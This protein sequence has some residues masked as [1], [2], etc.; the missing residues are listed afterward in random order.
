MENWQRIGREL[1][2]EWCRTGGGLVEN[3]WRNGRELMEDLWRIGR[4][5]TGGRLVEDD[6]YSWWFFMG[7]LLRCSEGLFAIT[8][9][10]I[11]IP[12]CGTSHSV[13]A[14]LNM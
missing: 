8:E 4:E 13:W 3:W 12:V 10:G 7:C 5:L 11:S 14:M 6:S 2:E 1:V 9:G